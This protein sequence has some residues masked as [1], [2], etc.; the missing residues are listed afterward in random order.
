M[1][2]VD[3]GID[4]K[5]AAA[6]PTQPEPPRDAQE[7]PDRPG[8]PEESDAPQGDDEQPNVSPEEQKMYDTVVTMALN[9]IYEESSFHQV[10][11][12]LKASQANISQGIG[13]TGAMIMKSI[14]GGIEKDGGTVPDDVLFAAAGEVIGQLCDISIGIKAMAPEQEKDV[15]E[16][17]LYEGMR[18]WGNEMQQTGGIDNGV[19]AQAKADL[20]EAGVQQGQ[21]APAPDQGAP[22]APP[23]PG[24]ANSGVQ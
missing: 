19:Q 5:V 21:P 7:P 22:A 17:A 9:Q 24:I 23:A 2:I 14:K 6:A 12:K 8:A 3:Q 15:S 13:H 10:V 4:P 20:D 18:I 16:A 1:G 11:D